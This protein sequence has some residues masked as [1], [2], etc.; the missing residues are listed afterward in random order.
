MTRA[1]L[2]GA[3]V[4]LAPVAARA[5][6]S[7]GPLSRFHHSLEGA[8]NC[9][10]CHASQGVTRELCLTCHTALGQRIAAG[11][12]L[13]ARTEYR[14]GCERCHV[15]HQG[16]G[17]ELVFWGQQGR[18]SFD[19]AQT[20]FP[21]E[22]RHQALGCESCHQANRI[23]D[24]AGLARGGVNLKRTFLG[25]GR[26]CSSCHGDPHQKQFAP[27]GCTDC[28]D[29]TA[30]KPA[31]FDHD[32]SAFPL[33]GAHEAV[34]CAACHKPGP[35]GATR[36][37]GTPHQTCASCH[38]D[39][40]AGRMG[41]R[42]DSCHTTAGWSRIEPGRFDHSRTRFPLTGLHARVACAGCHARAG[43][44][45]RFGGTPFETCA[46]CHRDPHAGRLG[47][48]CASCHSTGGWRSVKEGAFDHDRTRFPLRGR[49]AGVACASCHQPGK[50]RAMAHAS[51]SDCHADR[52]A[53]QLADRPDRGRCETCHDVGGW[54]PAR[55]ST[56]DHAKT[57]LPLT[58]A[59][60]A[61]P[62]DGC[63]REVATSSLGLRAPAGAPATTERF[64]FPALGC[65][66]C[67][68]DPHQGRTARAGTCEG[69]H[70]T[71]AW[72]QVRFDHARTRFPLAGAHATTPCGACHP[73]SGGARAF[74]GRPQAC[75]GCHRDPHQGHFARDGRTDC[76]RCHDPTSW[77]AA[78][79]DHDRETAFPLQGAHRSVPCAGCH[80]REVNGRPALRYSG[81]GKAC[82]DC[83]GGER[84]GSVPPGGR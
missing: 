29:A 36:F 16:A 35:A 55:F 71:A 50:P 13:H 21:L 1:L 4:L 77:R 62:C 67:H 69:C 23:R 5:Q 9:R 52:H 28:H 27:R 31:R 73:G 51:C 64:H 6:I 38:A 60:L 46:S 81:I 78:R 70:A 45:M 15:E 22:G 7:P 72:T 10:S 47:A 3:L 44:A 82:S 49:H 40:H 61:V 33:T 32:R 80:L 75:A 84:S 20:G 83:H 19:H 57:R 66:A 79:F 12:G 18:A 58:G 24:R 56:E 34:A 11:R 42:C 54:Q 59:H 63:H 14:V 25:L 26:E 74:A 8:R 2:A 30:F 76:A 39:P 53:G 37:K 48:G 65:D 17:F 43:G 68:G 41:A